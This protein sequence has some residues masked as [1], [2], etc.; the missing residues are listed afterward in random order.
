MSE[1]EPVAWIYEWAVRSSF[2]ASFTGEWKEELS[3]TKPDGT[4]KGFNPTKIKSTVRNLVPLYTIPPKCEHLDDI[5]DLKVLI[6]SLKQQLA[7]QH[8]H[9]ELEKQWRKNITAQQKIESFRS[10]YFRAVQDLTRKPLSDAT[11]AELWGEEHS[12]KT[13]MVK[14]FARAVEKAHGIGGKK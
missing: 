9:R 8:S 5:E 3:K 13:D 4:I 6:A 7:E 2:D 1:Q 10:G 12:G 11:I 14:S